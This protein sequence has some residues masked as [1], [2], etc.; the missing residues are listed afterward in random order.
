MKGS[1]RPTFVSSCPQR[2]R[3]RHGETKSPF[4]RRVR[5]PVKPVVTRV[6]RVALLLL[7]GSCYGRNAAPSQ[8]LLANVQAEVGI[9]HR[10]VSLVMSGLKPR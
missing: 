4:S 7:Q 5:L 10:P 1:R 2:Q 3:V 9:N 8:M 6:T